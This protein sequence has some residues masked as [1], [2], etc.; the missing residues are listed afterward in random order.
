MGRSKS[1]K[2]EVDEWSLI[3]AAGNYIVFHFTVPGALIA[4]FIEN[5]AKRFKIRHRWVSKFACISGICCNI[6]IVWWFWSHGI[7]LDKLS[8]I[9]VTPEVMQ[10]Q[11]EIYPSW[12]TLLVSL[13]KAV[14][15]TF[16]ILLYVAYKFIFHILYIFTK[17]PLCSCLWLGVSFVFAHW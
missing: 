4:D 9:P 2:H 17:L 10:I 5:S 3:K 6:I 15:A 1:R 16:I 13:A 7:A 11:I 14:F 12:C 8:S